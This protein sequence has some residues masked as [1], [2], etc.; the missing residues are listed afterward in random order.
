[1]PRTRVKSFNVV[2]LGNLCLRNVQRNIDKWW[3]INI[4]SCNSNKNHRPRS[5]F[6]HQP[7]RMFKYVQNNFV[8]C[9][10]FSTAFFTSDAA[11]VNQVIQKL[12]LDEAKHLE[13]LIIP[14]LEY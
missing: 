2:S 13:L 7:I 3:E 1:M 11:L 6:C 12:T 14:Q 4:K 10:I 5:L 9:M 8:W